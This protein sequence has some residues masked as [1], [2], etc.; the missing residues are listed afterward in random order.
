MGILSFLKTA[1]SVSTHHHASEGLKSK[2]KL[3]KLKAH[4]D[5]KKKPPPS[6]AKKRP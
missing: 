3:E 1:A 2:E 6:K 5:K 4:A